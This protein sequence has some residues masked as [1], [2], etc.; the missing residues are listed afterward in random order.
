MADATDSKQPRRDLVPVAMKGGVLTPQNLSEAIEVAKLIAHSGIVPKQFDGN[1]GAVLVAIQ[2]GSEL[3]LSPMAALQ[4]V[5]VINGRP[6]VWGDAMLAIVTSHPDCVDV[7][8][9]EG[10]TWA[11]CLV[12]RRGRTPVERVFTV[13]DAK[14]AGLWGKQGPW[15]NYPRR[16]LQMR[17]RGFALRDAFPDALRGIVSTEEARDYDLTAAPE[18]TEPTVIPAGTHKFGFG[19]KAETAPAAA[20]DPA[21][22][23]PSGAAAVLA[24]IAAAKSEDE[25][26]SAADGAKKLPDGE[27][28]A[29]RAAYKSKLAELH[30][31]PY[32]AVTGEV[33]ARP[34]AQ[35]NVAAAQSN[36]DAGF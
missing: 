2:M 16:M 12:R 23:A 25:L 3:G 10:D 28:A 11:K 9:T 26:L 4:G 30:A 24:Q 18:F 7:V 32:D 27:R 1:P 20:T 22:V 31:E 29:V 5:A 34:P 13:D 33:E 19:K 21:P 35:R 8:E 36:T 17:A 15:Q 6:T 14:K